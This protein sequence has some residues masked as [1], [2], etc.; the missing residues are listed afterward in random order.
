MRGEEGRR[1]GAGLRRAAGGAV[2][3]TA[4][5][6]WRRADY[7]RLA[8][9]LDGA[10]KAETFDLYSGR[11]C[12]SGSLELGQHELAAGRHRLRCTAAGKNP[13][14]AGFYFGLDAI[15]LMGVK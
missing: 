4:L 12:P 13:A 10:A 8:V 5:G 11:V 1:R 6:D 2:S 9:A 14:S 7:G 15:D 3:R